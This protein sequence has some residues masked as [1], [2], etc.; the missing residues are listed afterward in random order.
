MENTEQKTAI[1]P[2][3]KETKGNLGEPI[4][5]IFVEAEKMFDKLAEL[6]KETA[7]K[8]YEFFLKR[9]G[10]FGKE[11]DDWFNAESKLLRPVAVEITE[12]DG[13]INV[14]AAVP[15]FKPD[16]IEI[17]VKDDQLIMSGR[18]EKKEEKK[19]EGEV[20]YTDW[21]SDRFFRQLTLPSAVQADNVKAEL[22]DGILKLT[23][24]KAEVQ[25]PKRIAVKAG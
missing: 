3:E 23:L 6:S 15:G 5:P 19:E 1:V 11:L 2:A 25:E 9:G 18:T 24:P 22:K 7:Q 8:A 4:S 13:K 21:E 14:N 10:E 17:S 20:V 16:E 12:T